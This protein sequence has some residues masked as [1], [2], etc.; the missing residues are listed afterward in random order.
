MDELTTVTAVLDA[1][2]DHGQPVRV[3]DPELSPLLKASGAPVEETADVI[4]A[5]AVD[6]AVVSLPALSVPSL[7]IWPPVETIDSH[8]PLVPEYEY[9]EPVE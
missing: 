5:A 6:D 1:D 8:V 2:P 4:V 7:L 9:S 3:E